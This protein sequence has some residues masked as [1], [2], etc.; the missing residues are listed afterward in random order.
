MLRIKKRTDKMEEEIVKIGELTPQ[1]KKVNIALKVLSIEETKKITSKLGGSKMLVEAI[2]GDETGTILMNL[3]DNQ[4]TEIEKNGVIKI[5]NGYISLYQNNMR[6]N[7]GK[8]GSM[9][10]S[11]LEIIEINKENDMSNREYEH[12]WRSY[13]NRINHRRSGIY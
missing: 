10:K 4:I 5:T 6:L 12:P 8:H 9:A 3:W 11:N 13:N 1:S 7:I 2:V